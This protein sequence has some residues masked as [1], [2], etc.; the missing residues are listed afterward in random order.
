MATNVK[1]NVIVTDFIVYLQ[2]LIVFWLIAHASLVEDDIEIPQDVV[3]DMVLEALDEHDIPPLTGKRTRASSAG[4][5]K[6]PRIKYD[7]QRAEESVLSDWLGEVPRFPDKQFERTF[8][9]KRH[10][11][12]TILNHLCRRSSFWIKSVCRAGKETINPYVKLLCALKMICYGI[13]GNAFLD[14]HQFGETTSRRCVHHLVTDL[15]TC[16]E[17]AEVYL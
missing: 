17:L 8:R 14:Y 15:V 12:D 10:M 7:Y 5:P 16:P 4:Q 1:D 6:R 13:S 3:R 9:I 11:V 2:V